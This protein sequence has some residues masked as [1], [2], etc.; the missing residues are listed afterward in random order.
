[1]VPVPQ[2]RRAAKVDIFDRRFRQDIG[3]NRK[4]VSEIEGAAIFFIA[5]IPGA[6][7]VAS[8][9]ARYR[10]LPFVDAVAAP[11]PTFS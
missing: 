10:I 1:M 4:I 7:T 11:K 9:F 2:D 3:D 5:G 6:E 8:G